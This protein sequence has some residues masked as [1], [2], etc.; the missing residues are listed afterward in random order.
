MSHLSRI[1]KGLAVAATLAPAPLMAQ[2]TI[3]VLGGFS[4]QYQNAEIEKP[5]FEG[6]EETTGGAIA[7]RFRS[8]DELGLKGYDAFR[9]LQS[10]VFQVMEI[11]PGYVS[12]DDPFV[13]GLDLP[14]IMPEI[15]MAKEAIDAYRAPLQKR[16][17]EKFD[18]E[19]VAI[20][21]Y[22]ASMLFCRGELNGLADLKGKKVRVF[23]PALNDLVTTFGATGVTLPFS[24]VY[25]SLQRGVV[26]CA[27]AASLSG[28]E[29][30]WHEVTDTLFSLP[31]TWATQLHVANGSFW[32]GLPEDQRATLTTAFKDME[33]EMWSVAAT[34]TDQGVAC[35]TGG[36]CP[37]GEP[38]DMTLVEYTAEDEA[39]LEDAVKSAVLPGWGEE[40]NAGYDACT[41]IW[42]ETVGAATGYSID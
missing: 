17:R 12:G 40:C 39:L 5:F 34:A 9:Q 38:A 42:N 20:W 29:A 15:G 1:A 25:P 7:A 31:L 19:V 36:D 35:N 28:Y 26:D 30:K 16:V 2:T 27:I 33:D 6:L 14:G 22:P 18:G 3:N 8:L 32:D 37:F 10:G 23:S 24:E 21:P 41:A 11:S 13:L 4:N